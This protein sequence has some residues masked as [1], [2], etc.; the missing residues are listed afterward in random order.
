MIHC[1]ECIAGSREQLLYSWARHTFIWHWS[2]DNTLF[3]SCQL[4]ITRMTI[5]IS[6]IKLNTAW[7]CFGHLASNARKLEENSQSERA[8]YCYSHVINLFYPILG[9]TFGTCGLNCGIQ[10]MG[11]AFHS[12]VEKLEMVKH[13]N[14]WRHQ[15]PA[16]I[17]VSNI[18]S[19]HTSY[20]AA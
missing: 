2:V 17:T 4:K 7:I 11:T 10:S 16:M 3:D 9:M 13:F 15:F 12:T 1:G 19:L 8:Y 20:L 18:S 5:R 14:C 6:T